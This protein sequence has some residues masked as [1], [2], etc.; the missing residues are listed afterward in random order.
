MSDGHCEGE[1]GRPHTVAAE[2][3]TEKDEITVF[4]SFVEMAGD[5]WY[6]VCRSRITILK[7][8][9]KRSKRREFL[10]TYW[11]QEF[12][13]VYVLLFFDYL[14]LHASCE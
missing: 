3:S 10:G 12:S 11:Q 2:E 5:G 8:K 7:T 4:L 9:M 13:A 6:L 14:S 1:T